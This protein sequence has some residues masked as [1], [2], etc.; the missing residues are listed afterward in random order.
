MR[1]SLLLGLLLAGCAPEHVALG[2]PYDL[3]VPR[4]STAGDAL[5]LVILAHGF[6]VNG[7]GQ[8]LVFPLSKQVDG[9]R[10]RYAL[11]NGTQ[12]VNGKRFWN[13]NESCCNDGRVPVD[14]VAFFRA[15]V[16]D[17]RAS[18]GVTRVF[19]VGHSNGG[20]MAL[21]LACDAPDLL[22]GVVAV[23]AATNETFDDCVNR[24]LPILFVHGVEDTWV[25]Y[26]GS[27]GR[28]LGPRA[29]AEAARGGCTGTWTELE[30]ADFVGDAELETKRERLEGC[31]PDVEL[32]SLDGVGHLPIFDA[33]WTTATLDWLT[34]RAP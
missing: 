14:D 24:P 8:D 28:F 17:V 11:P 30:R 15:L 12:D 32:W 1:V 7:V 23:S 21:R 20:G 10:F 33:R 25:P 4:D 3:Q 31:S 2:R 5:P 19:I 34:E 9:R 16:E 27:P 13:A 6:G 26:D 22:D 29:S 18:Y